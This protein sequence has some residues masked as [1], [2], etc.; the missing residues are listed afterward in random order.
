MY[1]LQILS[2]LDILVPM[3]IL[4]N[5]FHKGVESLRSPPPEPELP[6]S[7]PHNQRAPL[8]QR[9]SFEDYLPGSPVTPTG[10]DGTPASATSNSAG[11]AFSFDKPV[12]DGHREMMEDPNIPN[13]TCVVMMLDVLIKQASL[14]Y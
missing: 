2:S 5:M 12:I 11:V 3:N 6:P 13:T 4:L 14:Q 1:F 8:P 10:T 7:N 9:F